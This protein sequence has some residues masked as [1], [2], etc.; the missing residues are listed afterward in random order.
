MF[1]QSRNGR[2]DRDILGLAGDALDGTPLLVEV[3][4]DGRR[5]PLEDSGLEAARGRLRDS[6]E[7]LPEGLRSLDQAALP[8]TVDVSPAVVEG[9]E[10]VRQTLL[11]TGR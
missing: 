8:Y 10:R 6:L 5:L 1:R 9:R 7:M 2:A 3:M 11:Q 4:R